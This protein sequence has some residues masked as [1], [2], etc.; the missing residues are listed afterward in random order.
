MDLAGLAAA[1][2]TL[3]VTSLKQ[4]WDSAASEAAKAAARDFYEWL[5]S[6]VRGSAAESLA[7]LE[8]EP[9][10]ERNA[11]RLKADL[12]ELLAKD[13]DF[14]QALAKRLEV[15]RARG[16]VVQSLVQK[17]EGNLAVQAVDSRVTIRR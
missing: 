16:V 4:L 5:K 8:A 17:G 11:E 2:V 12:E 6:K 14:V 9:G 1:A 7:A 13:P 10:V 15:A 3:A